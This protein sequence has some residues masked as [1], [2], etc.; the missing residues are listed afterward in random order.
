[1]PAFLSY[2]EV[3]AVPVPAN[4]TLHNFF[5]H[6]CKSVTPIRAWQGIIRPFENDEAAKLTFR[7]LAADRPVD[8]LA[9]TIIPPI[10]ASLMKPHDNEG[11]LTGC[12]IAFDVLILE[13][14]P[15]AQPWIFSLSPQISS[16]LFPLHPHLRSDRVVRLPSR[17]L[18]G[19][20]V[21]STAEF[22]PDPND[23][24]I[25]Q[26]LNQ[27]TI[28]FAKHV[29]WTRTRRLYSIPDGQLLHDGVDLR[30][31]MANLPKDSI[32]QIVPTER[33]AW[34][35]IWLGKVAKSGRDHLLLDRNGPCWCGQG[36]MYRD[37]CWNDEIKI[38][39][40]HFTSSVI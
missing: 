29:I 36:K 12:G 8:V 32:W 16:G 26:F 31:L 13:F 27:A 23:E 5:R 7:V 21:Y 17:T 3:S 10:E 22:L 9:G 14:E 38:F 6:T 35:G 11:R 37:C 28:W 39:R 2:P 25:P 18:H 1:V 19:L 4:V 24:L 40:Q 20:C 15:P 30:S 34:S 33:T